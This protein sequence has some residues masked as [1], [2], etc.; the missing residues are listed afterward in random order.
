MIHLNE[1]R[2]WRTI[3]QSKSQQRESNM[4]IP[5]KFHPTTLAAQERQMQ[6]GCME[7]VK[8]QTRCPDVWQFRWSEIDPGRKC[9][10]PEKIV[11]TAKHC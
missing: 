8:S 11:G 6:H 4:A 9:L 1:P 7:K 3:V 5:G 2:F 10:C